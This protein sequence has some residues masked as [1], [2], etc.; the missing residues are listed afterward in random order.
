MINDDGKKLPMGA[1]ELSCMVHAPAPFTRCDSVITL[2]G[3]IL[4]QCSHARR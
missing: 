4:Q 1:H 2:I 3:E